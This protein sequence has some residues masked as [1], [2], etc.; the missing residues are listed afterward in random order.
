[1]VFKFLE[2]YVIMVSYENMKISKVDRHSPLLAYI[3]VLAVLDLQT[4]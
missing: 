2:L 4:D 1:M 3:N